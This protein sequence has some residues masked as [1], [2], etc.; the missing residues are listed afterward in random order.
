M[1]ILATRFYIQ[2]FAA[3]N[4]NNRV[5]PIYLASRLGGFEALRGYSDG[6]FID[7]DLAFASVEW[8]FPV[9]YVRKT[10]MDGFVFLDEGRVYDE[11]TDATFFK[12]WKYSAGF[13]LR[14]WNEREVSL[15]TLVATSDEGTRFYIETG[16]EW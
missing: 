13:G 16:V 11:I 10:G 5:T 15:S 14:V 1:R 8:R 9:F 2:R 7:N 6:R 3:D 4:N 12:D